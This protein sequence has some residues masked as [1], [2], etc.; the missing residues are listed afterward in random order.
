MNAQICAGLLLLLASMNTR[1]TELSPLLH[2]EQLGVLVTAPG[3][4]PNLPKDLASGLTNTLLVRVSLLADQHVVQQ[5]TAEVAIRYDL[6]EEHFRITTTVAGKVI[7]RNIHGSLEEVTAALARLPLPGLFRTKQL[8]ASNRL[9]IRV[10]ILLNP[11]DRERMEK[12]RKWVTENNRYTPSASAGGN[13]IGPGTATFN[14]V[15]NRIFDQYTAGAS[16][17]AA[18]TES[19]DSAPFR[20]QDLADERE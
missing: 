11:L 15:F 6:W 12:I 2:G 14:N 1:G 16:V 10:D 19:V 7:A 9:A 4:P 18:W 13:V 5:N 17:V 8:A 20:L 3:Y